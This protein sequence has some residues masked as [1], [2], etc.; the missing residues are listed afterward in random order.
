MT[1]CFI[2]LEGIFPLIM[3]IFFTALK[4]MEPAL[5][6]VVGALYFCFSTSIFEHLVLCLV[7]PTLTALPY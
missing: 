7:P 2:E 6:I 5:F 3:E 1:K 4:I